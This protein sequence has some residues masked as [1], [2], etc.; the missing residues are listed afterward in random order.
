[1]VQADREGWRIYGWRD[2]A[3]QIL[4]KAMRAGGEA[5]NEA[6]RIIN[7]LG[8]RGYTAFGTLLDVTPKPTFEAPSRWDVACGQ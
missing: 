3:K 1:M 2:A 5:R 6:E 4:E 8:W 7:Y